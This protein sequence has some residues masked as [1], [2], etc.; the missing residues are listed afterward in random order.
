MASVYEHG[1][2]TKFYINPTISVKRQGYVQGISPVLA[3]KITIS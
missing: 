2:I 1:F 3:L